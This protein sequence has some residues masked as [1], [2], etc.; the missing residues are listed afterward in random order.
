[1][2]TTA[3]VTSAIS[4][5]GT[6]VTTFN[7]R[8]GAVT[9]QLSDVTG[10]GGAPLASPTFTGVPA[11]PTATAGTNTTQ[12]ATTAFVTAAVAASVGVSS[13]NTRTGAV[14]LQLWVVRLWLR[15]RLR[16]LSHCLQPRCFLVE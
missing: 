4:A 9:L 13:F 11:A 8:S 15:L 6:G 5:I 12:L 16:A 2:A 14:T 10:V 1:L 3:F 7:T